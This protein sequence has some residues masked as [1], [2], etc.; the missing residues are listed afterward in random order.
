[1]V[2]ERS[3]SRGTVVKIPP[4]IGRWEVAKHGEVSLIGTRCTTCSETFFPEHRPCG[5]CGSAAT[6]EVRLKGPA[7]LRSYTIV[8]QLPTGFSGPLVVGYAELEGNTLVLAPIDATR[9]Q[10]KEGL[11]LT[12]HVGVTR[13][14]DDGE[15]MM[16]YRFKPADR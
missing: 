13:I 8:H 14:G 3:E 2:A 12:V 9:D 16:S 1:M 4:R 11:L 7:T 5:K 10:L 15:P 6:E